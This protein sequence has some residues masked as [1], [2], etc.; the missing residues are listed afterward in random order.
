MTLV[1]KNGTAT[2]AQTIFA[3]D[4]ATNRAT[5]VGR[6]VSGHITRVR[7]GGGHFEGTKPRDCSPGA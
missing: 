1:L 6:G 7:V 4:E 5:G 2:S 3:S